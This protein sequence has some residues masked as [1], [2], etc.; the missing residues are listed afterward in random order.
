MFTY[1]VKCHNARFSTFSI[2]A[3]LFSIVLN[4]VFRSLRSMYLQGYYCEAGTYNGSEKACPTG[5]FRSTV[6][7]KSVEECELCTGGKACTI[8]GLSNPDKGFL[9]CLFFVCLFACLF[10]CLSV[11]FVSFVSLFCLFV[12]FVCLFI[13]LVC[14]FLLSVCLFVCLVC[15]FSLLFNMYIISLLRLRRRIL[16]FTREQLVD[17]NVRLY[18]VR[19]LFS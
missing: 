14:L 2:Y 19:C 3:N 7:A 13:C 11:Q 4:E 8:P 5:T 9:F 16:V 12:S 6:G 1:V 10:V 15:L 18:I 17:P